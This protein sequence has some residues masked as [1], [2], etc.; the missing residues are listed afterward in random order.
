[1]TT[2]RRQ[3]FTLVELLVVIGIIALLISI[4][5]PALGKAREQAKTV[6]CANNMRQIALGIRMYSSENKGQMM[7]GPEW[8]EPSYAGPLVTSNTNPPVAMWSF[9]DL[10]WF[11]GYCTGPARKVL[12]NPADPSMK[13]GVWDTHHPALE[14]GVFAC[15]NEQPTT[16]TD[17]TPWDLQF[18]YGI[19]FEATPCRDGNGNPG[20]QRNLPGNPPY[21]RVMMNVQY[22]YVKSTKILLCETGGRTE[23]MIQTPGRLTASGAIPVGGPS[24]I[25]LRHGDGTHFSSTS[26]FSN[27]LGGNYAFGDG[28]VEYSREYHQANNTAGGSTQWLKDNFNRWWGMG[29]KANVQ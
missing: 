9:Q 20:Y 2:S 16:I 8:G 17:S 14:R 6:Q 27:K 19:N 4:L 24:Q 29:D 11:K 1:M 22:S 26:Y 3:A 21:F 7:S 28:H 18:Q 15:P 5:L 13:P 25:R 12:P 23:G 10:L